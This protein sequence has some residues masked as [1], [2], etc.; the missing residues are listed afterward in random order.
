MSRSALSH[1]PLSTFHREAAKACCTAW[2]LSPQLSRASRDL[3]PCASPSTKRITT[4]PPI[5][6]PEPPLAD[7][8]S[9]LPRTP[10]RHFTASPTT[11][12]RSRPSSRV[13]SRS[14]RARPTSPRSGSVRLSP[15]LLA[16]QATVVLTRSY[17]TMQSRVALPT[18]TL[19]VS[20]RL[21]APANGARPRASFDRRC[22]AGCRL[23]RPPFVS[24]AH[25]QNNTLTVNAVEAC[26]SRLPGLS[27]NRLPRFLEDAPRKEHATN[28][29]PLR[30]L[31]DPLDA[32]SPEVRPL[33]ALSPPMP[34]S[35]T[36]P[37][38]PSH[39]RPSARASPRRSASPAARAPRR[40][41]PRRRSRSRSTRRSRTPSRPEERLCALTRGEG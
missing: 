5:L 14:S 4:P 15:S 23:T 17:E 12:P 13:S 30:L 26:T 19:C 7:P 16:G 24:H 2:G 38:P 36:I 3:E 35:L 1:L 41:R 22:L 11:S 37:P 32:F 9:S 28:P 31:A 40:R 20:L 21:L 8:S 33:P 25:E 27:R 39:D 34:A 18:F 10:T 6:H 29:L